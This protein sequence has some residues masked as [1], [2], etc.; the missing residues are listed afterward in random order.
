M[1]SEE[2]GDTV[3]ETHVTWN[4]PSDEDPIGSASDEDGVVP[5]EKFIMDGLPNLDSISLR[6]SSRTHK[7]SKV[8]LENMR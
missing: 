2:G 4:M 6:L 8:T 3:L 5:Y 1:L 7:S